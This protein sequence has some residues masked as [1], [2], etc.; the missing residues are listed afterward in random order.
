MAVA[1]LVLVLPYCL[2]NGKIDWEAISREPPKIR[3][4][5]LVNAADE[6]T[7]KHCKMGCRHCQEESI[8]GYEV[9]KPHFGERISR[10]DKVDWHKM[11]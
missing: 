8:H 11:K 6:T 5:A 1:A 9:N 7:T 10:I 2:A 3:K 4:S